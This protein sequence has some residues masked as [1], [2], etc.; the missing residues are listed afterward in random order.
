MDGYS[1]FLKLFACA[2]I[3]FML[4]CVKKIKLFTAWCSSHFVS[5]AILLGLLYYPELEIMWHLLEL[6]LYPRSNTCR[7]YGLKL[8]MLKDW[9]PIQLLL[10]DFS[11]RLTI[12]FQVISASDHSIWQFPFCFWIFRSILGHIPAS[13][14][15]AR[16]YSFFPFISCFFPLRF[17]LLPSGSTSSFSLCFYSYFSSLANLEKV[18]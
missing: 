10:L 12:Q 13:I 7:E 11:M 4:S 1:V 15:L 18:V 2:V 5:C 14:K 6:V 8:Q 3:S 9:E 17:S 16:S